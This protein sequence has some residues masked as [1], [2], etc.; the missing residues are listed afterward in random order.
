M[1]TVQFH[2]WLCVITTLQCLKQEIFFVWIS[3]TTM[4]IHCIAWWFIVYYGN[5]FIQTYFEGLVPFIELKLIL[6]FSYFENC[7]MFYFLFKLE[8]LFCMFT[9][10]DCFVVLYH[11]AKVEVVGIFFFGW[12]RMWWGHSGPDPQLV[13]TRAVWAELRW[14]K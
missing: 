7:C 2:V 11:L 12:L 9:V 3:M 6:Q 8:N 1:S 5:F 13:R 4:G 14:I 10:L